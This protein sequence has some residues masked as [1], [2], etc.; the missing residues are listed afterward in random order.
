[1]MTEKSLSTTGDGRNGPSTTISAV[2]Q[3]PMLD[4]SKST[5][6][7]YSLRTRTAARHD[8]QMV[9]SSVR[10]HA[11]DVYNRIEAYTY[12]GRS[13]ALQKL[14]ARRPIYFASC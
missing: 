3:E 14:K 8:R 7:G 5:M 6:H 11:L 1:M 2:K 9:P 12:I 10:P 4:A 13:W